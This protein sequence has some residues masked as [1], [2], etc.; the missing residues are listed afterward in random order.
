MPPKIDVKAG[1][2]IDREELDNIVQN[3][4]KM[5]NRA[6]TNELKQYFEEKL[7]KLQDKQDELQNENDRLKAEVTSLSTVVTS[8]KSE[9][10][11]LSTSDAE[12]TEKINETIKWAN[13]NEQYSRRNNLKIHGIKLGDGENCRLAVCKVLTEDLGIHL[14]EGDVAVAH[15]VPGKRKP[16]RN[17]DGEDREPPPP[18]II[19]RFSE[20][21]RD[22]RDEAIKRRRQLK[23]TGTV[24]YEDLTTLNAKLINR[25]KNHPDITSAWS[26]F[27][28]IY[29][30]S[31]DGKKMKFE[32]FDKIHM[33]LL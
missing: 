12:R 31:S 33:K 11:Q 20:A 10:D 27:G 7:E 21:A 15:I 18:P 16:G 29:G 4:V 6:L 30:L 28:K 26:S 25:L 9:V 1:V 5:A 8:L 14:K 2:V 23:G 3:A 22:R 17:D 24:I 19:V 32:P 13:R